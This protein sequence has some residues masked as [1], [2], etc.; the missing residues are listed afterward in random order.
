MKL[1]VDPSVFISKKYKKWF[2]NY[3]ESA[4]KKRKQS[5]HIYYRHCNTDVLPTVAW[6][7]A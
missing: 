5:F 1:V 3:Y 2:L 4:L 6:R 7:L